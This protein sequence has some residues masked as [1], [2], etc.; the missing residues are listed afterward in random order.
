M[1]NRIYKIRFDGLNLLDHELL[2]ASVYSFF[3]TIFSKFNIDG[4]SFIELEIIIIIDGSEYRLLEST[5]L[6]EEI[7]CYELQEVVDDNYHDLKSIESSIDEI[8]FRF[9]I[10]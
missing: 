5:V 8:I 1:I 9:I 6:T 3:K 4:N 7:L 10:N 2:K